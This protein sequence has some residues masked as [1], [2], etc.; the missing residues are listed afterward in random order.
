[1]KAKNAAQLERWLRDPETI[2]ADLLAAQA[3]PKYD[4]NET[5]TTK[6]KPKRLFTRWPDLHAEAPAESA[7]ASNGHPTQAA[8]GAPTK[9]AEPTLEQRIHFIDHCTDW[10]KLL[11]TN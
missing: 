1:M 4:P 10:E 8:S 2:L 3:N 7:K 11:N 5:D 9:A 6:K